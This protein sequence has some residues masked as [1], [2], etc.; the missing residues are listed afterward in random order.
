M[1]SDAI[2][3]IQS[4][5]CLKF[6]PRSVE[7]DF[8][9]IDNDFSGCWSP[10]GKTGGKQV[11]NL[12][13]PGCMVRTGT[14]IHEILH[15]IGFFHEQNRY[16]R[17]DHVKVNYGYVQTGRE[18]NFDKVSEDEITTFGVA[19]D[20]DSVL[21]YSPYAFSMTNQMT[22]ESLFGESYNDR[23]GQRIKLSDGDIAK[24]KEMYCKN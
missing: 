23:M 24:V 5:T 2:D 22:I 18:I 17:D 16:D 13:T 14:V 9:A 4:K 3:E 1:I 7:K 20:T 10:V 6:F 19:Y 21:H 15:S 12:Q 8:I 11:V